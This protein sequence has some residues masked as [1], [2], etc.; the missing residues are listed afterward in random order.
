M[1]SRCSE[2]LK[3]QIVLLSFVPNP[4]LEARGTT[5]EVFRMFRRA[6]YVRIEHTTTVDMLHDHVVGSG[7]VLSTCTTLSFM[8]CRNQ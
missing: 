7:S 5:R 3:T 4:M 6:E 2:S 1:N 8:S